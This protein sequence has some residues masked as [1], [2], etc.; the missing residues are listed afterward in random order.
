M[1]LL[2][3]QAVAERDAKATFI[4]WSVLIVALGMTLGLLGNEISAI[5][6][7]NQVVTPAFVGKAFIHLSVVI[8]AWAGGKL[9]PAKP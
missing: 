2:T 3:N 4:G 6:D 8:G 7:W 9:M 5:T 1:E